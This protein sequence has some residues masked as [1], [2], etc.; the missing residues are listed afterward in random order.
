[1]RE[2]VCLLVVGQPTVSDAMMTVSLTRFPSTLLLYRQRPGGKAD[3]SDL[4]TESPFAKMFSFG[5]KKEPE[6]E[7]EPEKSTNWWTLN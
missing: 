4:K 1:M 7:P 2:N 3:D 5:K 6:P